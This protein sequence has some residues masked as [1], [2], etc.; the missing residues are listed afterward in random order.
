MVVRK[1]SQYLLIGFIALTSSGIL[2]ARTSIIGE[3]PGFKNQ[4]IYL[5]EYQEFLLGSY[6][7]LDHAKVDSSGAFKFDFEVSEDITYLGLECG[8]VRSH[9]YAQGGQSYKVLFE[10][11]VNGRIGSFGKPALSE[12]VFFDLD[13][14]DINWNIIDFNL[15]YEEFFQENYSSLEN[16]S[17]SGTTARDSAYSAPEQ[18]ARTM[19][20]LFTAF[21]DFEKSMDQRYAGVDSPFFQDYRKGVMGLTMMNNL[22]T[23]RKEI[24]ERYIRQ[25]RYDHRNPEASALYERFFA[26][27]LS[28]SS[29][30]TFGKSGWAAISTGGWFEEIMTLLSEDAF[31]SDDHTQSS[32]M[33]GI[34]L[35]AWTE[36][37][38][39][40]KEIIT[41]LERLYTQGNPTAGIIRERLER[42]LR[43]QKLRGLSLADRNGNR[44]SPEDLLEGP[45][46]VEFW[47]GWCTRC[48]KQHRLLETL[49]TGERF[50]IYAVNMDDDMDAFRAALE[51][52][53]PNENRIDVF[54]GNDPGIKQDHSIASLPVYIL[55]DS[56]GKRV[57]EG[58]RYT[59][60]ELEPQLMKLLKEA[61]PSSRPTVGSKEN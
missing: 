36:E 16:L 12:L 60:E 9:L 20:R 48:S 29:D 58:Y 30:A 35:D 51:Q 21:Q 27:Y 38:F 28:Q 14:A 23:D 43:G 31:I 17:A 46:V 59:I 32:I 49:N 22:T 13:S 1:V 19:Q 54:V 10:K 15:M 50:S 18:K 55:L 6:R 34:L 11:P 25:C 37:R 5:L 8:L 41:G 4:E 45:I 44:K 24:H 42:Q 47:A 33:L 52:R 57:S 40:R 56:E 61:R 53:I 7:V 3:A 39:P 2:I 26:D